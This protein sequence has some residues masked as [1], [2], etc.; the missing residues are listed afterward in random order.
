MQ[1]TLR[2]PPIYVT[3]EGSTSEVGLKPAG[4]VPVMFSSERIDGVMLTLHRWQTGPVECR[5][6]I[7]EQFS[8]PEGLQQLRAG[9]SPQNDQF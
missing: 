3:S 5:Q 4:A 7:E 2:L 6:V 9:Q 8:S 1:P